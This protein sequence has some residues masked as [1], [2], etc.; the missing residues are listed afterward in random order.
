MSL[1]TIVKR[2]RQKMGLTSTEAARKTGIS[3]SYLL[4]IEAGTR[5]PSP[6]VMR[7]LAIVLTWPDDDWYL[8][9]LQVERRPPTLCRL[10]ELMLEA[11]NI[12]LAEAIALHALAFS[13]GSYNGRYNSKVYY[14]MEKISLKKQ[15]F[16]QMLQWSQLM[17]N[18]LNHVAISYRKGVALYNHALALSLAEH[19]NGRQCQPLLAQAKEIFLAL[20]RPR[21]ANLVDYTKANIL[22]ANKN[23]KDALTLYCQVKRHPFADPVINVETH[24]GELICYWALHGKD[25]GLIQQFETLIDMATPL[26]TARIYHNM[27]VL[28][29]QCGEFALAIEQLEKALALYGDTQTRQRGSTIA[30]LCLTHILAGHLPEA[31]AYAQQ[32]ALV[33]DPKDTQD[34]ASMILLAQKL[35]LPTPPFQTDNLV[36]DDYEQRLTCSFH[37]IASQP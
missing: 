34:T 15:D 22:L 17:V 31:A 36:L 20:H 3:K 35:G 6:S 8:E 7:Q 1:N 25:K 21:E 16:K 28:H 32:Y 37:I 2:R 27:G 29:R 11:D 18:A 4:A 24:L 23:Y 19:H 30:E 13:Q 5:I 10:A 12:K 14:L 33:P 9:Y 26:Q